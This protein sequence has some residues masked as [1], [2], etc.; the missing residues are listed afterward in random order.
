MT[1]NRSNLTSRG[2]RSNFL[3]SL[4]FAYRLLTLDTR[5]V[6]RCGVAGKTK[7]RSRRWYRNNLDLARKRSRLSQAKRREAHP[8]KYRKAAR[9]W[10]Q[11]KLER[12]VLST[13]L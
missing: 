9:E 6:A 4:L 1:P 10:E 12:G 11:R 5:L 13:Y 7:I 8:R 2:F 3:C